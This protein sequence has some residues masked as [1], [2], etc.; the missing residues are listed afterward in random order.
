M[1]PQFQRQTPPKRRFLYVRVVGKVL[2]GIRFVTTKNSTISNYL[3]LF[4]AS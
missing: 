4:F 3:A 2:T 1:R